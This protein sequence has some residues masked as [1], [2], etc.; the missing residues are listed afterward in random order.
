M[1][2]LAASNAGWLSILPPLI[3]I[4]LALIT[5]EVISSLLIGIF[6]GALIYSGG[7]PVEMVVTTFGIMGERIGGNANILIFLGLLG[8][9]VVIVT[10]A[11]GSSAYGDWAAR[12]IKSRKGASLATSAL[13]CLIFI[14]DYFNCLSVG[15]VMRPVTDKHRIS[16]A[17]LAYLLDATAAPVCIIA[18]ISSWG[19]S[20]AS[21]MS[22]AGVENGMET[23]V[24]TIPYNLYAL[25]TIVM[26]ILI[27]VTKINFGPMAKFEKNAI[28]LGDL[29]TTS[30]E[31]VVTEDLG[32]QE[33]SKKGKVYD[34]VIPIAALI[35]F[36]V[37]AMS[38]TGGFFAGECG[39][40]ESFGNC[41][42]AL[43]LV[44]GSFCALLVTFVLFLPRKVLSFRDFMGG[45]T[46]GIKS[47]V[48]AFT[49]L[50][51]AWTIGGICSVD[52]LNT[53]GF[54]G[55]LVNESSFP[56][57][58]LPVITF[59]VAGFLGFSTGTSWGTMALLIPI[60]TAICTPADTAHLLV[61]VL[62][63]ILAGA[64]YGDHVSPISDTT[65]LSST[66]AGCNH[67]DHV[68]TQLVY[69]SIVAG[70]CA[71]GYILMGLL[72]NFVLPLLVSLVL[73]VVVLF[74]VNK[75]YQKKVPIDYNQLNVEL[76]VNQKEKV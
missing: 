69:A 5:K 63:S 55:N 31:E 38:Y 65:I 12:K 50:I 44:L 37:L 48:P 6:A 61:P 33:V 52:Y 21:Y 4:V 56:A 60:G 58:I 75:I 17:K 73:M 76:K 53:G 42:S 14:D 32:M 45:I 11:G 41:D 35:V 36:T 74:A 27:C 19:A 26:V 57:F 16:R 47:M 30:T 64:V 46:Q 10:K 9:L 18:P 7:N 3:A 8:A 34:L 62:A 25:L 1:D 49:I 68:S 15:T 66:G 2:A 71:V 70:C 13:G 20:V 43:S 22:D 54:V 59:V 23:F 51:L 24:R 72:N 29:H 39:F 67:I 40:I 28:E